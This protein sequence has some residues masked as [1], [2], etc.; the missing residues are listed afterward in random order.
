MMRL[1]VL[2]SLFL[3]SISG[4]VWALG[5]CTNTDSVD[6]T[7]QMILD[8]CPCKSAEQGVTDGG[9]K[10]CALTVVNGEVTA[11]HLDRAC[12]KATIKAARKSICGRPLG[13]HPCC[14]WNRLGKSRCK[15]TRPELCSSGPGGNHCVSN[16]LTCYY[17]CESPGM[18]SSPF[19]SFVLSN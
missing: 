11:G 13:Y 7:W 5:V 12:R 17:S 14:K 15:I 10:R 2:G 4:P 6:T 19:G 3:A 16:E 1:F 8:A 18:C 9:F